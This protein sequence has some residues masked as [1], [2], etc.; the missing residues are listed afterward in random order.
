M[1]QSQADPNLAE[2]KLSKTPWNFQAV[3]QTAAQ[4]EGLPWWPT[5]GHWIRLP[6]RLFENPNI[7]PMLRHVAAQQSGGRLRFRT[8]AETWAL[9]A[10]LTRTET[11][12]FNTPAS[13]SG[14]DAYVRTPE[15][16]KFVKCAAPAEGQTTFISEFTRPKH[17]TG[18]VEW[19]LYFPLQNPLGT[20]EIAFPETAPALSPEPA[21]LKKPVLFYGSS[22]TQGFSASRCGLTYPA[23]ISRKLDIPFINLGY[24]G[25]AKGEPEM[26]E[27]IAGLEMSLFVCDLDHNLGSFEEIENRYAPFLGIIRKAHPE[28]PILVVSGPNYWNDPEYFGRRADI[29]SRIVEE[30]KAAGDKHIEFLHGRDFW[31][32]ATAGD[33]TVDL[34]HPNDAGFARM[35]E[36]I[37]R[38]FPDLFTQKRK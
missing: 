20:L 32:P 13:L 14:L 34:T 26:A 18:E 36:V 25:N 4:I 30:A 19:T 28:L 16:L 27:A 22:I 9:Q 37:S 10:T 8:T 5:E 29:I 23:I 15:G 1:K 31:E 38:H 2:A 6:K 24:G 7:T 11:G 12:T 17:L 3:Q 35:A 21:R 33:M